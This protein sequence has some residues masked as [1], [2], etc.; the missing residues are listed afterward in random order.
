MEE[1]WQ[2][3][4]EIPVTRGIGRPNWYRGVVSGG[5]P[6]CSFT[7]FL[8]TMYRFTTI[9]NVT[10]D[11]DDRQTDYMPWHRLDLYK[12]RSTNYFN[13]NQKSPR[14]SKPPQSHNL[15]LSWKS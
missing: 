8:A 5:Y 7:E 13:Y 10:D 14:Q 12:V 3:Y 6:I 9:Q 15:E 1:G 4:A 11:D 2:L